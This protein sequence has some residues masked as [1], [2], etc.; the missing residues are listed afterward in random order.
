MDTYLLAAL[1]WPL[2]SGAL[3]LVLAQRLKD[4]LTRLLVHAFGDTGVGLALY[5][6]L[7]LPGFFLHEGAHAL[8]ALIL[9]VPLRGVHW[10]PRRSA[11]DQAVVASVQV[12]RR[13]RLRMALVA[14]APLMIG[15]L[16]LILL[17]GTA[18]MGNG[19]PRPWIR[20]RTW[21]EAQD[22]TAPGFWGTVYLI[23]AIVAHM[24]PSGADLNQVREGA[25]LLALAL[26]LIGT[27]CDLL[28]VGSAGVP[29]LL[30]H[31]GDS[32]A[33]GAALSGIMLL[34]L[35]LFQYLLWRK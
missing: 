18:S 30:Q 3:C 28:G 34:P 24:A 33:V 23:W 5:A 4:T 21:V 11:D 10:I 8:T 19:D 13:D 25:L 29:P 16:A 1:A 32:L 15:A 35:A 20:L 27:L 22:Q 9:G 26:L 2:I 6:V 14:I 12:E 17:T 31:L 7:T